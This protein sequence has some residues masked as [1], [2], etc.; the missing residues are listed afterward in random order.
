MILDVLPQFP[1]TSTRSCPPSE[2]SEGGRGFERS[3]ALPSGVLVEWCGTRGGGKV[4]ALLPR[5]ASRGVW[6]SSSVPG[7][8]QLYPV[9]L[10]ERLAKWWGLRTPQ[11]EL[12][13]CL[14]QILRSQLVDQ[15][16]LDENLAQVWG[17]D[18]APVRVAWLR[19][20]QIAAERAEASVIFLRQ[21]PSR[22]GV[23]PIA[24]QVQAEREGANVELRFVKWFSRREVAPW[25]KQFPDLSASSSLRAFG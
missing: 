6:V 25:R 5:L 17:E 10:R 16:I 20:L 24:I 19:R 22:S 23:W 3:W 13:W 11:A 12:G 18:D 4:E 7:T 14:L 1:P 21:Q 2:W 15:I 8:T 9:V